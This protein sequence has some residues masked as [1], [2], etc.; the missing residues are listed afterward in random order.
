MCNTSHNYTRESWSGTAASWLPTRWW[1]ATTLGWPPPGADTYQALVLDKGHWHTYANKRETGDLRCCPI[2]KPGLGGKPLKNK[3]Y[4][5]R[6][7]SYAQAGEKIDELLAMMGGME[8][9]V[10][11]GEELLLK[12]NLM[13]PASPEKAITTHPAVVAA[14]ARRVAETGGRAVIADCPGGHQHKPELLRRTYEACGMTQ[15]AAE[16]GAQLSYDTAIGETAFPQGRLMRR[17]EVMYPLLRADGVI[18]L[19]KL[20][21]HMF[22][23]MTGAVKNSFG[24]IPGLSKAGYHAKLQEKVQFAHMLLDLSDFVSPR[25]SVMDAVLGMEGEGPGASGTPRSVGLL[26][27]AEDPL[28]LDVV[29]AALMGLEPDRNPLLLAAGE[30]G[31]CPGGVSD[32]ELVGGQIEELRI[33]GFR[34]PAQAKKSMVM[35]SRL[36]S[37]VSALAKDLFTQTPRVA[38]G[39]CVGCGVCRD[40][41]P[42]KAIRVTKRGKAKI[43]AAQCVRCYCCHELCPHKA[44][45]IRPGLLAERT[46]GIP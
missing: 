20:K 22:M 34:L 29:A 43:G 41:C 19:C 14:V 10:S 38:A 26:L 28:A 31:L 2:A 3:V 42:A 21:S 36:P 8:R 11:A 23:N 40:S 33:P 7:P 25:L 32:V 39:R 9:Y 30:R 15:A 37:P 6:C 16:S 45:D 24:V 12:A 1:A 18:N 13:A 44:I 35:V 27:G 5:V 17:F 4:V 46:V